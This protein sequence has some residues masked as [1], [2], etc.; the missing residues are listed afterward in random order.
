MALPLVVTMGWTEAPLSFCTNTETATN[1]ANWSLSR[2]EQLEPHHL[3]Q[4][5]DPKPDMTE[6]HMAGSLAP[7]EYLPIPMSFVDVYV[8]DIIGATQGSV[9]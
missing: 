1:W 4:Q 2:E 3:E 5:A 8:D 7:R 9:H 6:Y